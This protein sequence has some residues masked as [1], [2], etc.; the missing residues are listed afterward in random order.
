MKDW[1]KKREVMKSGFGTETFTGEKSD[2]ML[3]VDPPAVEIPAPDGAKV[4]P[5]PVPSDTTAESDITS[6][7][8]NRKSRR[9]YTDE[10]VTLSELSY[11]LWATQGVKET[12]AT[13]Q[14]RGRITLR[15][16]PSAGARHPFETYLAVN[17]IDGLEPGLYRYSALN[18]NLV[19]LF[20]PD[21]MAKKITEAAVGQSFVGTAP[22]VFFW[23]C[24]PY[25]GE[26]RYKGASHKAMLLDAGHVCQNLYLAAEALKLG[27]VAIAAYSQE[28]VDEFLKL[29][30]KDEFVV[31]LAPV[32][33]IESK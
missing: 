18:H 15:T 30:G 1:I 2:Q 4:I 7:I 6:C 13:Y 23:A 9:K 20:T 32:G 11:M 33:R 19:Y 25:L 3:N 29:D 12:L 26:W 27:T 10:A 5:L 16:V 31:Y 17:N 24:K 8:Q 28:K 22:V 21:D 14:N